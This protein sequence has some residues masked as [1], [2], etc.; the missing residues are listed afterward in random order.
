MERHI[1]PHRIAN[2]I[3]QDNTFEGHY[4][5][6]EGKK[7]ITLYSKFFNRNICRLKPTFGKYKQREV[8][9]ILE[10]RGF[11]NKLGI[12]DAD[13]IRI[14]NN[15]KFDTD[16]SKAIFL[17]DYH[18]SEGMV[19]NSNAFNDLLLSISNDNDLAEFNKKFGD[20]YDLAYQL[21]FPLACLRLANK[22]Y[23]LGLSFKPEKPQGN[24]FKFKKFICDE[25]FEFLGTEKLI[26][27]IYEYSKNRGKDVASRTE[28]KSKLELVMDE[29]I[30]LLEA[31][32]G[33]DLCGILYILC[34]RGL[35]S[36]SKLLNDSDS[37]EEMLALSYGYAYFQRS[38]LF[39]Q[40]DEWQKKQS[41]YLISFP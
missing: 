38:D 22:R 5:L 30:D 23:N 32:N 14:P 29:N 21:C 13:F 35:K 36:K 37:I 11:N 16:Y 2:S 17:T 39:Q 3:E 28:I 27:T 41:I 1:T 4:L 10:E 26:N 31:V 18:D 25:K 20:V 9:D 8:Y 6:L 34:S 7:D 15:P 33:H 24:K 12:R 40:L 19:I